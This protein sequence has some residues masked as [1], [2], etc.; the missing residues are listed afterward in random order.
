MTPDDAFL[1][2]IV[3]NPDDDGLRLIYADYLDEKGDPRGE[4]I[5]VQVELARLPNDMRTGRR[6]REL[7]TRQGQSLQERGQ[8]WARPFRGLVADLNLRRGFVEAVATRPEVFLE[9]ADAWFKAGS[10]RRVCFLT[11]MFRLARPHV[12]HPSS[13]PLLPRLACPHLARL[14]AL[15]F[16]RNY[17]GD[18]GVELLAA[19]P[20]LP[21]LKP[22]DVRENA[23]GN[24][25]RQ[26]LRRGFGKG[27]CRF[28]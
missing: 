3:A 7:E 9:Q 26:E 20:H 4:F 16:T 14:S 12:V 5:R 18:D 27:R 10:I 13:A 6:R 11:A 23:I 2:D 15:D 22:L 25:A 24:K 17:L 19:S 8:E 1:A 21:R 28:S